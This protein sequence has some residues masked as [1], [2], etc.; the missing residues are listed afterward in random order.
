MFVVHLAL[1][2]WDDAQDAEFAGSEFRERDFHPLSVSKKI[3][4]DIV[5]MGAV[6]V[7]IFF[8]RCVER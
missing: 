3:S 7:P 1:A 2:L 6:L 8:R 5:G 4:A